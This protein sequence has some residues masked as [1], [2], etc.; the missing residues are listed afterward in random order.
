MSCLLQRQLKRRR[1]SRRR[2]YIYRAFINS[3]AWLNVLAW[4][5]RT[6]SPSDKLTATFE[7]DA[8]RALTVNAQLHA[9]GMISSPKLIGL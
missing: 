2:E 6:S 4:R 5:I 1:A 9:E 8:K 7:A 3:A